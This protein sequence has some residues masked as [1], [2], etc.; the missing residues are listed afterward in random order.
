MPEENLNNNSSSL[1][2]NVLDDNK[3][4][5]K[6]YII[7]F[8]SI[9]L[10]LIFIIL[11]SFLIL[12]NSNKKPENILS[13]RTVNQKDENKN[14]ENK[15]SEPVVLGEEWFFNLIKPAF[16]EHGET[17]Q[18]IIP[19][20]SYKNSSIEQA[21]NVKVF[22]ENGITF[23]NGQ[24]EFLE[25]NGFFL[26]LNNIIGDQ[27]SYGNED[28]FVD[29]YDFFDGDSRIYDR[30]A[31]DAVFITSDLALHLYHILVDRSFQRMEETRFQ[32]MLQSMT[33]SLFLNSIEK[34]KEVQNEDLKSSYKR[35]SVF[36]LV[37][38]LILDTG[39]KSAELDI[40]A[41]DYE[42]FAKYLE[43]LDQARIK[44]SEDEFTFALQEKRYQD[45]ILDDEIYELAKAELEL[46]N[47]AKGLNESPLF[48]PL[49]K[50][51]LNDYSQFKPRSHYT[52]NDILKSYFIAMMWY[53]RMGFTLNSPD[54]T[55]D[56]LLITGQVNNLEAN[57]EKIGKTWSNMMAVI[58]FFVGEVDDLTAFQ[59]TEIIK[60][61]YGDD[62]N[63][64]NFV[65]NKLL[66]KFQ[67]TA[68]RDLNPP[69][70]ISEA[71]AVYDDA[72]KREE[73]M[74]SIMQFRFMGQRFTPDAYVFT[75]LTQGVG[76]PDPETGQMLPSMPTA[77]M[78]I[79]VIAPENEVLKKYFN[80]WI[81]DPFRI[82][83]Q[84]RESDKIIAKKLIV[85]NKEFSEYDSSVWTQNMYWSWLNCYK[86]LLAGY[87]EGYPS[88]MQ[89]DNWQNK[90]LGTVL[91]SYAEL[92]HDTLLY[93]KQ[94]YSELGGGGPN[95]D[96]IPPVVKGYVEP[97]LVF[98]N[99]I[100]DLAEFTQK[101]L[102]DKNV[103][104]EVFKTKFDAFIE[105]GNFFKK[106]AE[107]EL[108]NKEISD[109]DFEKLRTI[110]S[111][112][113]RIVSPIMGQELT[114][115]EKRAGI[116][117]D[118][119]TDVLT[120]QILYEATGKPY[121]IYVLVNDKNGIRLTR[122]SV[123]SHYEFAAG[124]DERMADEDWQEIVYEEEKEL[125]QKD[126]WT[127]EIVK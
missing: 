31:D 96:E 94:S 78:P 83:K 54:L 23:S 14:Q 60:K 12:Q 103:F 88:F 99:R 98:W 85:L 80:N 115:K 18:N 97:D 82:K 57:G 111:R 42:T 64:G 15:E 114:K 59:Y 77:L 102:E 20:L 5:F 73:L 7:C 17:F 81:N 101:G 10:I 112:L 21:E 91:G 113:S 49:R 67:S 66:E 65:N 41:E 52:K 95:P 110:S 47:T 117:A 107:Q 27:S 74:R 30:N 87:G 28:D 70:I 39:I 2:D 89:N 25:K 4:S 75:N 76:S 45:V 86:P 69:R 56:A 22:N 36:Y 116:I 109:D 108:K 48:T 100:I 33:E 124:L 29:M 92:K 19:S 51:F 123:F 32:P 127:E 126:K 121:I 13:Q 16:A 9:F 8:V 71:L 125:P 46:I 104:P 26:A 118:I 40:K 50:E 90:N 53:G 3:K 72:D 11:G 38:L 61:V 84:S 1:E 120:Q 62:V 34:Y 68:A 105:S 122:G 35:L 93:A 43:G 58:D 106:I 37:P 44:N 55:R 119:H 6:K 24:K 79:H 63:E